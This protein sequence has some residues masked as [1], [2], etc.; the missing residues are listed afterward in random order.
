MSRSWGERIFDLSNSLF[1]ILLSITTLYPFLYVLIASLSDPAW[2]V[3]FRGLLWY[4][5]G[6]NWEAYIM[7]FKNPAIM[8]GYLNTILYVTLGT[9]LNI[10]MT[11]LGAYALSRHNL[12]WKNPV[13]F[14]I[15]FTMFFSG[16]L[17]PTY[18]LINDLG[19]VDT[20]WALLIPSAMSAYNLIIM[21]TAFQGVPVSLEESAKLDGAND[22]TI[23][24]RV[25]LPLSMPVVAVMVLFYGV[26]HWN[27]WF[28]ALIYLRT[29][30]LYPL[31]LIL[32]EILIT[33]STESMMTGVSGNDKMPIGETIKY[34]TIIVATAPILFLY[35]FLQKYFVKGVMIGAIKG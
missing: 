13:M 17:I 25:I 32:R 26:A 28:S 27:S 15:V 33:N 35:P 34:A 18:L 4:P 1:L 8:S 24:F 31:Q 7:V 16:G 10:L 20:R 2:I 30:D 21:R 9:S 6:F 5:K 11:S 23:L 12:M 3:Q 22:F 19:M 29:R 14:M